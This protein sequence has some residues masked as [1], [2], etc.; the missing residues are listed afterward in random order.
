MK[1][2]IS[3]ND[4]FMKTEAQKLIELILATQHTQGFEVYIDYNNAK[5]LEYLKKMIPFIKEHKLILQIH[6]EITLPLKKQIEYLKILENFSKTINQKI[7][8]TLHP[9]YNKNKELSK[10]QTTEYLNTIIQNIDSERIM[11]TLENLNDIRGKIRLGVKDIQDIVLENKDIFFC[12]DIGHAI[13]KCREITPLSR[14]LITKTKNIHIHTLGEHSEDHYPITNNNKYSKQILKAIV[15]L[16]QAK[17]NKNVEFNIV[18]EYRLELCKGDTTEEKI[19]NY[20]KEI[21][22]ITDSI[23]LFSKHLILKQ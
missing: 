11:I 4:K 7:K 21:D 17:L 3:I 13:D 1:A 2:L 6:G 22:F 5:E 23:L 8:Y 9:I 18:Y 16:I 20:L 15:Q 14:E 12:F 10:K 19:R